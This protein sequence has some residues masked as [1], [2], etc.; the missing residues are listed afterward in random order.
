MDQHYRREALVFC[1]IRGSGILKV[2]GEN[3]KHPQGP[4]IPLTFVVAID[5]EGVENVSLKRVNDVFEGRNKKLDVL[6]DDEGVDD[7]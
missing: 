7:Y 5:I 1:G 3:P 6:L 2:Y 4:V